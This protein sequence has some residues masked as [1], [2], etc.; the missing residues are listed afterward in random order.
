[1]AIHFDIGNNSLSPGAHRIHSYCVY[2]V[3]FFFV[4]VT[5]QEMLEND[6]DDKNHRIM[7]RR[8]KTRKNMFQIPSTFHSFHTHNEHTAHTFI[9][10]YHLDLV[11]RCHHHRSYDCLYK[12]CEKTGGVTA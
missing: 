5:E 8:E 1:M 9:C 11:Y 6:V 2:Y 10:V 7:A 4:A 3:A 12:G